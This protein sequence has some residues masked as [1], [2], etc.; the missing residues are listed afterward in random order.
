[1]ALF[2]RFNSC[3]CRPVVP[4]ACGPLPGF[5]LFRFFIAPRSLI[6]VLGLL[7]LSSP[8]GVCVNLRIPPPLSRR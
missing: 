2:G 7:E 5:N 3:C 8:S 6:N 1:M 4:S